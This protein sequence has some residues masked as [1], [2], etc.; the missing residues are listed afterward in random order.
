MT[1]WYDYLHAN[2]II[3]LT[4]DYY[5]SLWHRFPS[6]QHIRIRRLLWRLH[7]D[8]VR[9]CCEGR[10]HHHWRSLPVRLQNE[11]LRQIEEWLRRDGDNEL[12]SRRGGSYDKACLSR[13]HPLHLIGCEQHGKLQKRRFRRMRRKVQRQP[14][15]EHCRRE[16]TRR[17]LDPS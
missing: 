12:P 15:N 4:Q 5:F 2:D 17:L 3:A 13:T 8:W 6:S 11:L 7:T 14:R 10:R 16:R 1:K 9:I